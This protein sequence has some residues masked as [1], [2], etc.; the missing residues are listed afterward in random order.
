MIKPTNKSRSL[1]TLSEEQQKAVDA[2]GKGQ[3]CV[4]AGAGSG[5]TRVLVAAYLKAVTELGSAPQNVLAVTFTKKAAYEMKQR[6]VDLFTRMGRNDL[7]RE[8]E[9]GWIGTIDSFCTRV[10]R[11]NPVECGVDPSFSVLGESEAGILMRRALEG[12]LEEESQNA[13]W[14]FWTAQAGE[15]AAEKVFRSTYSLYRS[16]GGDEKIFDIKTFEKETGLARRELLEKA[17]ALRASLRNRKTSAGEAKL[18]AVVEKIILVLD[19]VS[20][21]GSAIGALAELIPDQPRQWTDPIAEPLWRYCR[22]RTQAATFPYKTE[23]RRLFF[24]WKDR[25]ETEKRKLSS[26]DFE[27]L[28]F[29]VYATFSG[30]GAAQRSVLRH[31]RRFFHH[32]FVDE[33]QDTSRL[34]W[35]IL[36]LL[37]RPDNFFAVGDIQQSIYRFRQAEPD[38]FRALRKDSILCPLRENYRSRPGILR[39]VNTLFEPLFGEE[40]QA[41]IPKRKGTEKDSPCLELIRVV[42]EKGMRMDEARVFEARTIAG[43]IRELAVEGT[44]YSDIAILM[45]RSTASRYYEKELEDLGIP[46]YLQKGRG[47]YE[48]HEVQDLLNFLRLLQVP[49]VENDVASA[50]VLRSPLVQLSD[51]ALYWLGDFRKRKKI[52]SFMEAADGFAE[53]AQLTGQDR[54]KLEAFQRLLQNARAAKDARKISELLETLLKESGYEAKLLAM[55]SGLQALANVRK[56]M[57]MASQ[58]DDRSSGVQEFVDWVKRLSE[59]Q[60]SESEA[61][62]AGEKE[63]VVSILTVHSAKGLEFPVVFLADLG[64]KK[65]NQDRPGFL[66]EP[67]MGMG[68]R[69]RSE[70][71][72]RVYEDETYTAIFET[73]DSGNEA[74][75]LRLLYV[76][77]TRCRD[78]LILCGASADKRSEEEEE[79]DGENWMDLVARHL[80]AGEKEVRRHAIQKYPPRNTG[81]SRK[82][83]VPAQAPGVKDRV[84]GAPTLKDEKAAQEI[85]RRLEPVVKPYET[86]EDLTVTAIV[87]EANKKQDTAWAP[88]EESEALAED[89]DLLPRNEFGIVFHHVMEVSVRYGMTARL[90]EDLWDRLVS[91]LGDKKREEIKA[92]FERFWKT[93]VGLEL[94]K[95]SRLYPELPFIY[96]TRHGIMKGQI[97][98]VFQETGGG[99][100]ILDYKTNRFSNDAEKKAAVEIYRW[101][102]GL[103]SLAFWRLYGEIPK[104]TALYFTVSHEVTEVLWERKELETLSQE[105]EDLYRSTVGSES[106]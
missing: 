22:L 75:S 38:I 102:L 36:E 91:C 93:P 37:K 83:A 13:L 20:D 12:L 43:R 69:M 66:M 61:R 23:F 92:S 9:N 104:K 55:P 42:Q 103:Y 8:I 50:A 32:I 44:P 51:E 56:L 19:G 97:D 74:E 76:A 14:I 18:L 54:N 53:V 27:D 17:S 15:K 101:Q 46:Y 81:L 87:C 31:Y 49:T 48:Q 47:F 52:A 4:S 72:P 1:L 21:A 86:L 3:V 73:L 89:E 84:L 11:E 59:E 6:L 28:L 78:R 16:S 45:R 95:A 35:R 105:L 33:F 70:A 41:L 98:L 88:D 63:D 57:D 82:H 99:W 85:E 60:H 34:Q 26:Y 71:G 80:S 94:K 106:A 39:F 79:T 90:P 77:M 62:L 40:F 10:L 30:S 29:F 68:A 2:L 65:R 67:R 25:Y 5:K 64:G 7:R 58:A 96:K 100:V 24:L